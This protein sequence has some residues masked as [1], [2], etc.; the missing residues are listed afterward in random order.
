MAALRASLAAMRR[1]FLDFAGVVVLVIVL[2]GEDVCKDGDVW[3]GCR[4][5][6]GGN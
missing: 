1:C 3:E 6:Y 4:W 5:G 2:G